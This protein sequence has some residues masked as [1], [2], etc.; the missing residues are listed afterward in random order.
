MDDPVKNPAE[1]NLDEATLTLLKNR[2]HAFLTELFKEVNPYLGRVCAAN[3][4]YR[5]N[6]DEVIHQT[7]EKFFTNVEKFEGRSKIRTFICGILFNKIREYRRAEGKTV[8][9]DDSEKVMSHSFTADGWWKTPPPNPQKL[10]ELKQ[11][12]VFIKE[13]M[14]GLTEQQKAAFFM[15]EVDDDSADSISTVLEVSVIHLRVILFRAKDK[16]RKCLEGK[17]SEEKLPHE[18]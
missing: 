3:S 1:F 11:A 6:A 7:W 15:R 4:I 14:E 12:G 17:T 2:D 18:S 9:E 16:L 10:L 5:E 13:C 8:Y